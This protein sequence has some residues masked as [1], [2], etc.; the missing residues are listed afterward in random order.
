MFYQ[1]L[2][3]GTADYLKKEYGTNF[4]FPLH[5]HQ[6]FELI[7]VIKGE[8]KIKVDNNEYFVRP[9]GTVLV[10]PNQIHAISSEE[11]EHMLFIFSSKLVETFRVKTKNKLP[12]SNF[13][14][15][16]D[17][18][19]AQLSDLSE[20]ASLLEIKGSLYSLCAAFN[21]QA[22]YKEKKADEENL[23]ANLFLFVEKNFMTDCTLLK[24]ARSTG[25]DYAYVSRYFKRFVGIS[26]HTYVNIYR[27]NHAAHL[28]KNTNLSVLQCALESGYSSLR[29]FNRNFISRFGQTPS[30]FRKIL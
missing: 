14:H 12:E 15:L 13:F 22:V 7:V 29:T 30:D 8:M 3:I 16:S 17:V 6:C 28:L 19:Y 27:L 9:R 10:F 25:Y 26:F 2:H 21:K 1:F 20:S 11:S 5:L 24:A 4:N 18:L 23:L